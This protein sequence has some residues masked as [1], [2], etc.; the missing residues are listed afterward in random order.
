MASKTVSQ[1]AVG[2]QIGGRKNGLIVLCHDASE[3]TVLRRKSPVRLFRVLYASSD[4][5]HLVISLVLP[6]STRLSMA[7]DTPSKSSWSLRTL[8]SKLLPA[9]SVPCCFCARTLRH[10]SARS[11]PRM[12]WNALFRRRNE[13]GGT[14]RAHK[15]C[16]QSDK[17][18]E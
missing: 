3:I 8:A 9:F 6:R 4:H 15:K 16:F 10:L 2:S 12:F 7:M 13:Q 1:G 5:L 14:T 18:R 11:V 17:R